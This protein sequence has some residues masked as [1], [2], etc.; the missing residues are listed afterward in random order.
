MAAA[1]IPNLLTSRNARPV[2]R[3]RGKGSRGLVNDDEGEEEP[4]AAKA[5]K[6]KIV[7]GTDNDANVSRMSAVEVGYLHDPYAKLFAP[8]G[9]QRRFPIINRGPDIVPTKVLH[10]HANTFLPG[11]YVRTRAID[12][13]VE[14]F[15]YSRGSTRKQ[16]I[17]LGAGSDT[18]YFRLMSRE[19]PPDVLYHELDFPVNTA[20]KI[21]TIQG[22]PSLRSHIDDPLFVLSTNTELHAPNYHIHA[23]DLRTLDRAYGQPIGPGKLGHIDPALP[24]LL[25]SEC[26]LT[27]L[28]PDTADAV[29]KHFVGILSPAT[30]A[31]LVLYEPINPFDSFGKVMIANLAARGIVM[32]TIQKYHSL[33]T[34]KERLRNYGFIDGGGAEDVDFLYQEWVDAR[35]KKRIGRLEM[36]DE[37]EELNL[38]AKHYCVAWGF[39][40]GKQAQ[41]AEGKAEGKQE[42]RDDEEKTSIWDRW[43]ALSGTLEA[44][45]VRENFQSSFTKNS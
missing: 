11:T 28:A 20:L 42:G 1:H 35:E 12:K 3:G 19:Q 21:A 34:Q 18:R 40:E 36:L 10:M 22:A 30:P 26:C 25:I 16:V 29:I 2:G 45:P 15:L 17:G 41:D 44:P 39:R 24:T 33:D 6:D 9:S 7:Q 43:R 27:Y 38:L 14:E 8:V 37:V 31:A 5:R 4:G 32:Q 23:I 13:L